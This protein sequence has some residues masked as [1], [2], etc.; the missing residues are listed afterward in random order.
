MT[1]KVLEHLNHPERALSSINAI[2]E[3]N[4]L[5]IV[6]VPNG[7]GPYSLLFDHFRN[8]I[9][10]KIFPNVGYSDHVQAFTLSRILN[11]IKKAGFEV[12]KVQHSDFI[13]LSA[14]TLTVIFLSQLQNGHSIALK[15]LEL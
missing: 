14:P 7:Y 9:A 10:S 12:L 1:H 4:G 6:T 11:L 5:L 2:L 8:K 15:E 13:S 3:E